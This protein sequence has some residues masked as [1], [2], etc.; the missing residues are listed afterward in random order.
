MT[1]TLDTTGTSRA[2]IRVGQDIRYFPTAAEETDI[3]PGPYPGKI[4]LVNRDG[5]VDI[6]M[7]LPGG[8][9]TPSGDI[10]AAVPTAITA[11]DPTAIAGADPAAIT[12]ADPGAA[13]GAFTDP[14]S[15]AEMAT[16][17][18]R[19]N[20]MRTL[21]LDVKARLAE[22]RT[23]ILDLKARQVENRTLELDLKARQAQ[24]RTAIS[25]I[26][27]DWSGS[28]TATK[29]DVVVGSA[30]GQCQVVSA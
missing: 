10:G 25:E 2:R 14:P 19:V 7:L 9:A 6:S 12:A 26:K 18:T 16:L 5:T 21:D 28:G 13:L 23:L 30:R 20:E 3:G 1:T 29:T 15:A 8:S 11:A 24:N 27:T 4:N 17:R 22:Y